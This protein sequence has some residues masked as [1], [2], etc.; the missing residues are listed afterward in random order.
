V[1]GRPGLH[2]QYSQQPQLYH[3][4]T[5]SGAGAGRGGGNRDAYVNARPPHMNAIGHPSGPIFNPRRNY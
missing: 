4:L 2:Q 5:H 1:R 3:N